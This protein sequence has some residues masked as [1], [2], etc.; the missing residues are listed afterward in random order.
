MSGLEVTIDTTAIAAMAAQLGAIPTKIRPAIR[1][2]LNDTG[3]RTRTPMKKALV[4]QT[5]L[6]PR[7]VAAAVKTKRATN[8]DLTYRMSSRGGN[9]RL[10]YFGA[11]E[12]AQG[13][14]AAPRSAR[15]V[16]A[17]TFMRAGFW[18]KRVVKPNWNG[19][20]F[21]RVG[22]KT[23]SGQDKFEVVRS[24][25][26]IPQEMI[27]GATAAAFHTTSARVLPERLAHHLARAMG[28]GS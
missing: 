22:G 9:I 25:V 6:K 14:S 20:V 21:R 8:G 15:R 19:Q 13:V 4:V 18:P 3:D 2:A 26:F 28:G 12:T 5:G 27:T 1:M 7:V 11:R 24:G 10:K 16:F 23:K 17:G